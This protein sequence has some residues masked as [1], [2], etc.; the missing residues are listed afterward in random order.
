M[1]GTT[2]GADRSVWSVDQNEKNANREN[3]QSQRDASHP[4][5]RAPDNINARQG[6]GGSYDS[7]G[8]QQQ[9]GYNSNSGRG[10]QQSAPT[11]SVA[12]VFDLLSMDDDEAPS[13]SGFGGGGS[14]GASA[15]MSADQQRQVKVRLSMCRVV[16]FCVSVESVVLPGSKSDHM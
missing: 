3:F 16:C 13:N 15:G 1:A 10:G 14:G 2:T 8:N 5:N 6:S 12:K 7:R 4:T 9:G 11:Q